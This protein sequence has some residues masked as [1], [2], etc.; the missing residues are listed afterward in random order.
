MRDPRYAGGGSG[1][2][3]PHRTNARMSLGLGLGLRLGGSDD[4]GR[5]SF[6][7]EGGRG[8]DG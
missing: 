8:S 7:S 5:L 1:G 4:P 2:S 3:G 6:D